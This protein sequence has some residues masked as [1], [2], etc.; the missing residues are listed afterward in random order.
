M[1]S[2]KT[3]LSA[4]ERFA[5][6]TDD[7]YDVIM[8]IAD[9]LIFKAQRLYFDV[10]SDLQKIRIQINRAE[11]I[12]DEA[13]SKAT[14][15]EYQMQEYYAEMQSIEREIDY[16]LSRTK[17]VT[18]TD[19]DGNSTTK[20]VPDVDEYALSAARR[21]LEEA[22]NNYNHYR[23]K[24]EL[25]R[26]LAND[27]S[28]TIT[29]FKEMEDAVASALDTIQE[30]M[31]EMKKYLGLMQEE[32]EYNAMELNALIAKINEYLASKPIFFPSRLQSEDFSAKLKK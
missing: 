1:A 11:I 32:A 29:Y 15:Y 5:S 27:A 6:H 4:L 21:R 18:V 22:T 8:S 7:T 14:T 17:T 20:T 19:S 10:E 25:A 16:I 26:S 31:Y 3:E 9:Q 12:Y 30:C 2:I 23:K 13:S 24:Y 28:A